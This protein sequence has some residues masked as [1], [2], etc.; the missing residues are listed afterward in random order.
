[1]FALAAASM[2]SA[3]AGCGSMNEE[4]WQTIV[5]RTP[6]APGA[7]CVLSSETIGSQTLTTPASI[8]L[9]RGAANIRV[10]CSRE[11][12]EDADAQIVSRASLGESD[13][14]L[15]LGGPVGMAFDAATGTLF[16]YDYDNVISMKPS[17]CGSS[18]RAGQREQSAGQPINIDV[19][20]SPQLRN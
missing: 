7:L 5:I 2:I 8:R 1:M 11:C 20:R 6:N 16:K 14:K 4:S 17:K 10:H 9:M 13:A 12:F 19:E 18:R 3:L 15:V